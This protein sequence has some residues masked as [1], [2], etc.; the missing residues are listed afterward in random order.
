MSTAWWPHEEVE[1]VALDDVVGGDRQVAVIQLDVEGH[2]R[3]ALLGAMR[4][5]ERCRP[6][7]VLEALPEP[8]W[9][10]ASLAPLGYEMEGSVHR[11]FVM[12][13]R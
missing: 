4:T 12:R 9:L 5:I 6:L 7:I 2:E 13:C 3:D 11:N 1:L 10:K 8:G